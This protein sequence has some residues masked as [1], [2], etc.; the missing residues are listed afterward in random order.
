MGL[1]R[2]HVFSPGL[3]HEKWLCRCSAEIY[4][5]GYTCPPKCFPL[6]TSKLILMEQNSWVRFSLLP[7]FMLAARRR[8]EQKAA[9]HHCLK[10]SNVFHQIRHGDRN[11]IDMREIPHVQVPPSDWSRP[12]PKKEMAWSKLSCP[13]TTLPTEWNCE[14]TLKPI[15]CIY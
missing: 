12:I 6:S 14:T 1:L 10:S 3:C 7:E 8:A 13:N 4:F 15:T 2:C 11:A 5:S 9:D